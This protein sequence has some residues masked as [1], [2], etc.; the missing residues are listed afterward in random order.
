MCPQTDSGVP[1]FN[2]QCKQAIKDRKKT[3]RR[4]FKEPSTENVQNYKRLRAS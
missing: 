3:Q 2:E 4:V 1:W